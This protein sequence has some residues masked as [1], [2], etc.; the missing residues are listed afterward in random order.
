MLK[1]QKTRGGHIHEWRLKNLE[2][3]SK[4]TSLMISEM[5]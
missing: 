3:L 4:S 1:V 2:R 5:V